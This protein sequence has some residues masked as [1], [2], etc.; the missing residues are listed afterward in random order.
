MA[1]VGSIE[2]AGGWG[3]LL[4]AWRGLDIPEGWRAEILEGAI[5]MTP[6]RAKPHSLIAELTRAALLPAIP[7][8]WGVCQMLGVTVPDMEAL[9]M[10]DLA[11][12][13]A[14]ALAEGADDDPVSAD[15]L[16]LVVEITSPGNARLNRMT[17]R[18]GYAHALVPLYLLIDRFDKHGPAVTLFSEP[19]GSD[20][21]HSERVPFGEPVLI[22]AP[23]EL[24]LET[25]GFPP[26]P[27]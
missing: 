7:H 6:P 2:T 25:A 16:E 14:A 18:W 27:R 22:P 26:L 9:Y 12:T 17:K 10:P 23:F 15:R 24:R 5:T 19:T 13:P 11:V 20:Y 1:G 8:N 21:R 3:A 4:R